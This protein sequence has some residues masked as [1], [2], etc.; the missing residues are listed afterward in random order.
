[1]II[2]ANTVF[3]DLPACYDRSSS[4]TLFGTYVVASFIEIEFSFEMGFPLASEIN[5]DVSFKDVMT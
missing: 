3:L 4:F 1:M 5:I 2:I